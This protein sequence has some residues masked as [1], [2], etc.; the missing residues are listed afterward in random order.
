MINPSLSKSAGASRPA[1]V[2]L[3]KGITAS[4]PVL[5]VIVPSAGEAT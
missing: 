1:L 3:A 2:V 5:E 4:V